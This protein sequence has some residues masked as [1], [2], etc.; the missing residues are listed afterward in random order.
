MCSGA[1]R[2]IKVRV[3]INTCSLSGLDNKLA[4]RRQS[5]CEMLSGPFLLGMGRRSSQQRT[6]P[7]GGDL[8]AK[9]RPS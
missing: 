2:Q 7:C 3:I 1:V 8:Q 6:G 4:S 9:A 5:V